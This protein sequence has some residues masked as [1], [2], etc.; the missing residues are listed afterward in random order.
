[1]NP[2]NR[3]VSARALNAAGRVAA[4]IGVPVVPLD[5]SALLDQAVKRT[6]LSDFGDEAF[7]EPLETLLGAYQN[8]ADLSTV[9]R[10]TARHD[11]IQLLVNRLRLRE[12]RKRHPPI[13]EETIRSPIFI[14]GLP[15]AG[16]APL[17]RLM[18]QDPANRVPKSWE[19][20]HPSPPPERYGDS[21]D[22]RIARA[23]KHLKHLARLA[24]ELEK[25]HPVGALLPQD[26][27]TLM[28]HEFI[29][30]KFHILNRVPSYQSWLER[31]DLSLA[32]ASHRRQL[33]HLQWRCPAERWILRAPAHLFGLDAL[34]EMFPDARIIQMHRDPIKVIALSVRLITLLRA[35]GSDS[36][37]PIAIG[38]EWTKRWMEGL[39][40]C[41]D[42]RENQPQ[43]AGRFLDVHYPDL[44]ADP[45]RTVSHIYASLSLPL[46]EETDV[47]MQRF[48]TENPPHDPGTPADTLRRFGLDHAIENLRY[49]NYR[50]HFGIM[51]E[52]A[53]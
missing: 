45:L 8:E 5:E 51:P 15:L 49:A 3:P 36:V 16:A 42:F 23:E 20:L 2:P 21:T 4:R 14:T 40:H 17:H 33:Q 9:G 28:A 52:V 53:G 10:M 32:Y 31:D 12:D 22:P 30:L 29:S 34:F 25:I 19:V 13:A 18:A 39:Q 11:I 43:L 38:Q 7:R 1:M 37:D 47:T 46:T 48:L 50:E 27:V 44:I 26:C 6:G 41:M 35:M 24:P